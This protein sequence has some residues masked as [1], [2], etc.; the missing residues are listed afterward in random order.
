[1]KRNITR[2]GILLAGIAAVSLMSATSQAASKKSALTK[3]KVSMRVGESKKISVKNKKGYTV[4]W[5]SN[6]KSVATVSKAGK[7]KAKRRGAA[8]ITAVLQNKKNGKTYPLLCKVAVKN[9]SQKANTP[10]VEASDTKIWETT[11]SSGSGVTVP[12]SAD[13][14]TIKQS[15]QYEVYASSVEDQVVSDYD[16]LEQIL[17]ALDQRGVGYSD[18]QELINQLASYDKEY[19]TENSLVLCSNM[20]TDGYS[21]KLNSL[22]AE[23]REGGGRNLNCNMEI[24]WEVP[25]VCSVLCVMKC[26]TFIIEVPAGEV[27]SSDQVVVRSMGTSEAVGASPES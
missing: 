19:F 18:Q 3:T 20:Q 24:T 26:H 17:E 2:L 8:C 11:V 25:E 13:A 9:P 12:A 16:T 27:A 15:Y 23:G 4:S 7:I 21:V 10:A 6:K 14:I 5:K 1:M 22:S